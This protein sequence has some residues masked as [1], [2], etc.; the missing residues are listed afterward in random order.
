MH[1]GK[2][3]LARGEKATVPFF[4]SPLTEPPQPRNRQAHTL[5]GDA[6][7]AL[8]LPCCHQWGRGVLL[9]AYRPIAVGST[10]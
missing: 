6:A 8:G 5:G 7:F 9:V 3:I 1:P 10:E 2:S 4:P